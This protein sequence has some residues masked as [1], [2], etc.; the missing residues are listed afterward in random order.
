MREGFT[1]DDLVSCIVS[2]EIVDEDSDPERGMEYLIEG[3]LWTK[4]RLRVKLGID[5]EGD[6]VFITVYPRKSAADRGRRR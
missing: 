6:I 5:D 4:Q 1:V 2:G 3:Q